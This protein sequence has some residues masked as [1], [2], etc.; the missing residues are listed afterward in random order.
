MAMNNEAPAQQFGEK[1]YYDGFGNEKDVEGQE[2]PKHRK[3]SRIDRPV[4]GSIAAQ[5]AGFTDADSD[6][7]ISVGKQMEMEAGNAIK[8]R[9]CS[10]QKVGIFVARKIALTFLRLLLCCSQSTSVWLSCR[11]HIHTRFWVWFPVLS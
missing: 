7:S 3:M 11:F 9:T 10:W 5:G 2:G 8:Y 6:A 4:T 1:G